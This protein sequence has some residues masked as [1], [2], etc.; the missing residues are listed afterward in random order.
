MSISSNSKQRAAGVVLQYIQLALNIL[1]QLIYTP[2]ILR[3][4]GDTEYGIY[5][6]VFS[7]ISYL[8]LLSL[9]FGA[10]YLRYYSKSIGDKNE[11]ARLNGLYLLVFFV[12]GI[13]A[14]IAGLF[15]VLN[16][17]WFFNESYTENDLR[18]AKVLMIVLTINMAISFPASVFNSYITSQEKFIFQRAVNMGKTVIGPAI[19]IVFLLFGY[20]SIGMVLATTIISILVDITNIFF[21]FKKIEMKISFKNVP[22]RLLRDIFMFS[23]FI[24]INQIIE[25]VNW[26][27]DKIIL[28]KLINGTAVAVY[29]V[30][31]NINT[32]F[33]SFSNAVSSVFIPKI[34]Q[35]VNENDSDTNR[36]LTE[37]FIRVGRVQWFI[38]CFIFS[39][40]VFFGNYF[41]SLWAGIDYSNG[42]YVAVLLMLGALIPLTQNL[43]IEIQRAK[44]QH[45]FRSII[46]LIMA[47]INV[48]MSIGFALMWGEIGTALGTTISLLIA[49][50]GIMNVY[51]HKKIKINM[52]KFWRELLT[53]LPSMIV[54][55]IV[56]VF[57]MNSITNQTSI[58]KYIC[59]VCMYA[60]TYIIFTFAFGLNKREKSYVFK[61][62]R[63]F[64]R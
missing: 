18:I 25:Q 17:G 12:I 58:I 21:C 14:L 22:V 31:A 2:I 16:S 60:L 33:K 45:R 32:M 23:A 8:S 47:F 37:L 39:G 13:I 9:G 36:K 4:L 42:Y 34:Y 57:C 35:I 54:P 64:K 56:G 46:Y 30:G 15:L 26:E 29:A 7:T 3:I 48:G 59:F 52:I 53:T 40:F 27:T 19:S 62:F 49:N 43:G 11:I 61:M 44:N 24:A 51:Y 6:I 38:L 5:N 50:V 63:K 41:V 28:G 10:S 20:G 55:I 1:I